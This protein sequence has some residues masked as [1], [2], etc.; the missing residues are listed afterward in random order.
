MIKNLFVNIIHTAI[1]PYFLEYWEVFIEAKC[2][3]FTYISLKYIFKSAKCAIFI[4]HFADL[5]FLL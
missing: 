1:L 2:V 4:Q 5:L 3:N